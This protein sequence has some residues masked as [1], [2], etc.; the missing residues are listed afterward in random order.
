ME[1]GDPL[2]DVVRQYF[3]FDEKAG[4][5]HG[6]HAL[7]ECNQLMVCLRG[8]SEIR[9]SKGHEESVTE[10]GPERRT[11]QVPRGTWRVIRTLEDD[12][13]LLVVCD[14]LYSKD[15]YI[16]DYQDFLTWNSQVS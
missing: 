7:K 3:L 12:T 8:R 1:W 6:S 13:A 9:I 5:T 11:V 2:V 15:D 10:L 4:A 16:H 14:K